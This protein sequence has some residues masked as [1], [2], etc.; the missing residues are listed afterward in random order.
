[1]K[2]KI[3]YSNCMKR[4]CKDCN[5]C[6]SC[7]NDKKKKR[8]RRKRKNEEVICDI[9]ASSNDFINEV[10]GNMKIKVKLNYMQM[11]NL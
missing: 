5:K 8:K 7:F 1:M 2:E 4:K 9:V 6:N 11:A 3:D 10:I